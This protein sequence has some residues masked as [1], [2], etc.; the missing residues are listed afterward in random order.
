MVKYYCDR[1]GKETTENKVS[2]RLTTTIQ[3]PKGGTI[4]LSIILGI[5]GVWNNGVICMDCLR[6]ILSCFKEVA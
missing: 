4:E 1:C 6:E 5:N 2:Q 3:N